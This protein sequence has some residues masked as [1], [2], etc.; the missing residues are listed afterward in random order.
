MKRPAYRLYEAR[1]G[2]KQTKLS[3]E[4]AT[5]VARRLRVSRDWLLDGSGTPWPSAAEER[6]PLV[7][8]I[9]EMAAEAPLEE[10]ERIRDMVKVMLR[11][12]A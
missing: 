5:R 7:D 9:A 8:E 4:M 6:S 10:Q 1:P 11:K 3:F 2:Q 12:T